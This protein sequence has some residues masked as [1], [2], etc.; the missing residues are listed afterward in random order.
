MHLKL[1]HLRQGLPLSLPSRLRFDLFEH[2]IYTDLILKKRAPRTMVEKWICIIFEIRTRTKLA[3]DF[4]VSRSQFRQQHLAEQKLITVFMIVCLFDDAN[5]FGW[6]HKVRTKSLWCCVLSYQIK[7]LVA[8]KNGTKVN[9]MWV[10]RLV[11]VTT[12]MTFDLPAGGIRMIY[13]YCFVR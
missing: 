1:F 10:N 7:Q 4:L 12:I 13:R 9:A 6:C 11:L 2:K 3:S 5:V 8:C